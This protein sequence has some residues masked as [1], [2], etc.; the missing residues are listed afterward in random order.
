MRHSLINDIICRALVRAGVSTVK[1]PLGLLTGI[2][3][4]PDGTTLIPLA[5]RKCLAWHA[6]TLDTVAQSHLPS[7][8]NTVGAGAA[9]TALLKLQKYS[10]LEATHIVVP[11]AVETMDCWAVESLDFV[12]EFRSENIDGHE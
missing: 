6:T 9:H 11:V 3:M 1:E 5:R 2:A 4:R 8:R 10:A 12:R 7:I